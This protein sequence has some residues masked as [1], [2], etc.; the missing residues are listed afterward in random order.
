MI[1]PPHFTPLRSPGGPFAR[2]ARRGF[3]LVELLTVISIMCIL[4]SILVPT[5][6]M[7]Q[8]KARQAKSTS[9]LQSIGKG[10]S[11]YT[12]DHNQLLPAPIY[13]QSNIPGNARNSANPTGATWLEEL[14]AGNYV[15]GTFKHVAGT[16]EIEVMVWPPVFTD[17]QFLA[18][19]AVISD[20]HVR[21]YGMNTKPFLADKD[22]PDRNKDFSTQRQKLDSLPN[23]SN[24][25]VIGTSN[26]VTLDPDLDGRFPH[27]GSGYTN[28]DPARYRDQGVFLFLD[29]SVSSLNELEL[30]KILSDPGS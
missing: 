28:G 12:L 15:E 4:M 16:G 9:N 13:A 8:L 21:G 24:N 14:I 25:L 2:A 27:A 29:N 11:A 19:H 22:S 26:A 18:L 7:I 17:P 30:A 20:D 5:V 3:T 10:L 1:R 23:H 6:G